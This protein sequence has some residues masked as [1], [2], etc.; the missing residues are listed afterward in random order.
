MKDQCAGP[1]G[2]ER[3]DP[4]NLV[5]GGGFGQER[6]PGGKGVDIIKPGLD[7]EEKGGGPYSGPWRIL[8]S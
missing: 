2:Q 3:R 1:F 6:G 8:T 4:V 5:S 7:I